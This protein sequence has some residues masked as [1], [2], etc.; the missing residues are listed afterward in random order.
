MNTLRLPMDTLAA[1]WGVKRGD[2]R[3]GQETQVVMLGGTLGFTW[4]A[5]VPPHCAGSSSVASPRLVVAPQRKRNETKTGEEKRSGMK[6]GWYSYWMDGR[7][8]PDM[9]ETVMRRS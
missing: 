3:G 1:L 7:R 9:F 8:V 5:A 4:P 2:W 6:Q